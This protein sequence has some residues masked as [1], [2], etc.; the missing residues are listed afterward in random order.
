MPDIRQFE[1]G[2][3]R[4]SDTGKLDY[5]G[6]FNPLVLERIAQYMHKHRYLDNGD[7]RDADN[8]QKGI[9]KAAYMQSGWRHFHDWWKEHRGYGSQDG[10]EEALCALV[11]NA[12]G[13]LLEILKDNK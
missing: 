7:I 5:E 1:T 10:V 8:W 2:A 11:F 3:N 6:F 4:N 12:S 13:Y 9:P